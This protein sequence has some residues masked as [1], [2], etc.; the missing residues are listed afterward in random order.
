MLFFRYSLTYNSIIYLFY[1][2]DEEK[3]EFITSVSSIFLF[4][5]AVSIQKKSKSCGITRILIMARMTGN[6]LMNFKRVV[7]P[8]RLFNDTKS[9]VKWAK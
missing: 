9:A 8:R 7:K 4:L 5:Y 1:I 3:Q 6:F 2:D